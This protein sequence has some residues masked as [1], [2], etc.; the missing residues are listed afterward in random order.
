MKSLKFELFV[1]FVF[2]L[3]VSD[4]KPLKFDLKIQLFLILTANKITL[5]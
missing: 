4:P 1:V 3:Y 5:K 2:P